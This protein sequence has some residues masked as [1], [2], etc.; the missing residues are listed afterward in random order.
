M[1]LKE[2]KPRCKTVLNNSNKNYKKCRQFK[3]QSAFKAWRAFT[4][5][6]VK[7]ATKNM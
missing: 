5:L 1:D 7:T 6:D 3:R 4:K 2:T